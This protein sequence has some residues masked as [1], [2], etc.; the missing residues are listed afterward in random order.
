MSYLRFFPMSRN[1]T[2]NVIF[3][4]VRI[5]P[6]L[7][8]GATLNG[9]LSGADW[10]VLAACSGTNEYAS[11]ECA[12]A[13]QKQTRE[14]E[15]DQDEQLRKEAAGEEA[16]ANSPDAKARAESEANKR[17]AAMSTQREYLHTAAER[18]AHLAGRYPPRDF[19]TC[20]ELKGAWYAP[21]ARWEDKKCVELSL[22]K[23]ICSAYYMP[24]ALDKKSCDARHGSFK[25]ECARWGVGM[26]MH[27]HEFRVPGAY[28]NYPGYGTVCIQ[29]ASYG[30]C[31]SRAVAP[32]D[33]IVHTSQ[34]K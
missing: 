30:A 8:L 15:Y 5:A 22:A 29:R 18:R 9:C 33:F 32:K 23:G 16:R 17:N 3:L 14:R 21:C 26:T 19:R 27:Y 24:D 13:R 7:A 1:A 12:Q 6:A 34:G 31:D 20:E 28:D 10:D 2:R 11:Q 4:T 25:P